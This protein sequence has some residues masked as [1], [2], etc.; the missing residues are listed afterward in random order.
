[1]T[2]AHQSRS[3]ETGRDRSGGVLV[4]RVAP[5]PLPLI[6]RAREPRVQISNAAAFSVVRRPLR[7][8]KER[9]AL[10]PAHA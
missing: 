3:L 5:L 6:F 8:G 10:R 4:S 1:V 7:R 9:V 2:A